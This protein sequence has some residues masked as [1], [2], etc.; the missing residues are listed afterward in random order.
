M[1]SRASEQLH[2]APGSSDTGYAIIKEK[3]INPEDWEPWP[4]QNRKIILSPP[5][6]TGT[7]TE[8][9]CPQTQSSSQK[10]FPSNFDPGGSLHAR[11][12]LCSLITSCIPHRALHYISSLARRCTKLR[13]HIWPAERSNIFLQ[14]NRKVKKK[15]LYRLGIQSD[16]ARECKTWYVAVQPCYFRAWRI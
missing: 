12:I 1:F 5:V 2:G 6:G 13:V 8:A 4:G 16:D 10:I 9:L 11:G 14:Y 7:H 3:A 15:W